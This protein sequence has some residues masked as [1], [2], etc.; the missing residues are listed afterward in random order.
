MNRSTDPPGTGSRSQG[1]T[2]H[3]GSHLRL[4][5]D[6]GR[7]TAASNNQWA[8]RLAARYGLTL[9]EGRAEL[10]RLAANGW[11]PWEFAERFAPERKDDIA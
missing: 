3:R 1:G 7:G 5:H 4:V 6:A 2:Q 10:R 9:A 11:M 8:R